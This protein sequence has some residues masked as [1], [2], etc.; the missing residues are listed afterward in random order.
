VGQYSMHWFK[1]YST[2]EGHRAQQ[3]FS[4]GLTH[5]VPIF[6]IPA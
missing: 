2:V 6:G 5:Q 4:G 3:N 1:M